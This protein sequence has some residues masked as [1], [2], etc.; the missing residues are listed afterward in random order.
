[1]R[2]H[3]R[4]STKFFG[5]GIGLLLLALLSIGLTIWITRQLDGGPRL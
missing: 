2:T 4:L 3:Q 5:F 1:M